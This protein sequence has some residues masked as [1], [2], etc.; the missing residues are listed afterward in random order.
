MGAQATLV[1]D[2]RLSPV[3][4]AEPLL[5]L[6]E[7]SP[8]YDALMCAAAVLAGVKLTA[9]WVVPVA[10]SVH[11]PPDPS[12]PPLSLAKVTDPD[13]R[14]AVPPSESDTVA[15]HV[16]CV[17]SV[18]DEGAQATPVEDARFWPSTAAD[19]LLAPCP[20]SPP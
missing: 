2:A 20:E 17:P 15:V 6:W 13:G 3:T 7:P 14:W 12:V 4:A 16:A 10:G 11:V 5:P 1:E 19:P 18:A 8:P 9:H